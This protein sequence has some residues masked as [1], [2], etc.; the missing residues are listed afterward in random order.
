MPFENGRGV[1][2][3]S[4]QRG[5]I[6]LRCSS[7]ASRGEK[8][9]ICRICSAICKLPLVLEFLHEEFTDWGNVMFLVGSL[10]FLSFTLS[11]FQ[12]QT[13]TWRSQIS[14]LQSFWRR[15]MLLFRAPL[16]SLAP[17]SIH[18]DIQLRSCQV[19]SE[20][21]SAKSEFEEE[22]AGK[23]RCSETMSQNSGYEVS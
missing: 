15:Q 1:F 13:K 5:L 16:Q 2:A 14:A 8:R 10:S 17:R 11:R 12:K 18:F 6:H 7:V 3:L 9:K 19:S 20:L 21:Q 4:V 22:Q 23:Q